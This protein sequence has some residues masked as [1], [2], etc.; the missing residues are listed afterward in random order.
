MRFIIKYGGGCFQGILCPKLGLIK[1]IQREQASRNRKPEENDIGP[2]K[3]HADI[4][5]LNTRAPQ[6]FHRGHLHF[7]KGYVL[8]LPPPFP[9]GS[10]QNGFSSGNTQFD[11]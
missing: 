8:T 5:T 3:G 2:V 9:L 11:Q 1:T 6:K 10:Y 7:S 4:L